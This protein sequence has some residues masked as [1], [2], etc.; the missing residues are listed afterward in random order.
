MR[1]PRRA[2]IL[3]LVTLAAPGVEHG[4]AAQIAGE[5][6]ES[7]I[8]PMLAKDVEVLQP[9]RPTPRHCDPTARQL[10]TREFAAPFILLLRALLDARL[11]KM[12]TR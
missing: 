6:R 5:F 10:Q 11:K 9:A 2:N 8:V 1:A 12:R 3:V 7:G 4:L